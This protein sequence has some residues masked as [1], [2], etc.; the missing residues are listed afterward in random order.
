MDME[1]RQRLIDKTM[2]LI[3]ESVLPAVPMGEFFEGNTYDRS[4]GRGIQTSRDIP[5]REYHEVFRSIRDRPDVQ[6]VFVVINELPA[7][8]FP[9]DR[10]R[11][12]QAHIV[13]IIT[14]APVAEIEKW[15]E[16][17]EPRGVGEGWCY[18]GIGLKPPLS[19]SALLPGMRPVCIELL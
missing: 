15:I 12:P 14:S 19:E 16:Q 7:D 5:I 1:R 13:N 18:P 9:E 8:E 17:L 10:M 11:W 6:E 3:K 2:T 4:M